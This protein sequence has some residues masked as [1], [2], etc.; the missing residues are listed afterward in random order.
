MA[1]APISFYFGIEK[2]QRANLDTI[3]LVSVEWVGLVRDLA[4]VIAPDLKFDV[5]FEHSEDGSVWLNNFIRALHGGDRKALAAVV[6]AVVTFFGSG[7]ALHV[8]T[9]LGDEFWKR[10]GH[11]H[12]VELSDAD[13]QD[14]ADRVVR[15]L[16]E[17]DAENRR[18][19]II[20]L[21][22]RDP[23]IT[24][25]GVDFRARCEGPISRIPRESFA[26]Y[27]A[28]ATPRPPVEKDVAYNRNIDVKIARA[29]LREGE[30]RPRW[31]FI[32]GDDEWSAH[33]E[34]EEF[35][36]ALNQ[37]KT[38]L[39]LAVGQHMRVDVAIDMRLVEG[40]WKAHD[41]RVIR[42]HEPKVRRAQG[43]LGLGG[44]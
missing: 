38:G 2:G 13:K 22:D 10:F 31:R 29:S 4:A 14:I 5:E 9:D 23:Q 43:E 18:R 27:D 1:S 40:T 33:I 6:A 41:R 20:Q 28:P 21:A 32:H 37:E 34:D 35:I 17:T 44:E 16:D 26:A 36:W 8:Q 11:E 15:A 30:T 42:V 12:K 39:P 3:A 7:P 19:K 24:S 25:V